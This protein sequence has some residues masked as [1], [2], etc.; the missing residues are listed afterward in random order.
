MKYFLFVLA[1]AVAFTSCKKENK[2]AAS[3]TVVPTYNFRCFYSAEDYY[4]LSVS[5]TFSVD[6]AYVVTHKNQYIRRVHS[7]WFDTL[8]NKDSAF[9]TNYYA[10]SN[11]DSIFKVHPDTISYRVYGITIDKL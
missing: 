9:I 6:S 2:M 10:I 5:D 8:Y 11:R 4:C 3:P 1:A 7:Q